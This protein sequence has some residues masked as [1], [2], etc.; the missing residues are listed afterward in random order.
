M[1]Q[2][3]KRQI[4]ELIKIDGVTAEQTESFLMTPPDPKLGDW[5]LP[6]FRFAK[7][8]RKSPVAIADELAKSIE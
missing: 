3:V 8:L 6:C 5:S 4:A 2:D 7:A 1:A